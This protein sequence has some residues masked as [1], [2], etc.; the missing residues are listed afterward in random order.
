MAEADLEDLQQ[1]S[2]SEANASE[3]SGS[4]EYLDK[5]L[6]RI[7]RGAMEEEDQDGSDASSGRT[8]KRNVQPKPVLSRD[9][10]PDEAHESQS[11]S[12]S[13]SSSGPTVPKMA[14]RPRSIRSVRSSR[15]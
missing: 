3:R 8:T 9:M 14:V 1:S 15:G 4:E 6:M 2:G 13:P 10:F 7:K 12:S 11:S 5:R